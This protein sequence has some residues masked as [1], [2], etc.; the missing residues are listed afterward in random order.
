[1]CVCVCVCVGSEYDIQSLLARYGGDIV[2]PRDVHEVWQILSAAPFTHRTWTYGKAVCWPVRTAVTDMNIHPCRQKQRDKMDAQKLIECIRRRPVLYECSRKRKS[3]NDSAKKNRRALKSW[4]NVAM[5]YDVVR[6]G[7]IV[8]V[9]WRTLT[10]V[11]VRWRTLTYVDY[12]DVRWRTLTYVYVRWRTVTYVDVR[13]RTLTYVDVRWRTVTYVDVR[14]RTLTY[15]DVR[16]RTL[17]YVDVRWRTV[18]ERV[19][20]HRFF[21]QR[22]HAAPFIAYLFDCRYFSANH[23]VG[24]GEK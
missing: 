15:G 5:P 13:W 23:V 14:W 19:L 7:V 9:R 16:W 12:S 17:T 3:C 22:R 4:K 21:Q 11:D 10:Y 2:R 18:S 1:M 20:S 24:F 8:D 6:Q